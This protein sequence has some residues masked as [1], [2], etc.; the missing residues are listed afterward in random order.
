MKKEFDIVVLGAGA[1]G[2]M[3]ALSAHENGSSVGIFEK[4]SLI[5]GTAGISGGIIWAP[6]N[7]HMKKAGIDDDRS[8]SIEYFMSLS[9]GDINQPLLEAFI[10]NCGEALDFLEEKTDAKFSILD[11]YPDYYLDRPGALKGGGRAL[12]NHLFD[13]SILGDW[14]SKVRN[15]GMPLPL[16]LAETPLGGG[17]GVIPD[18]IMSERLEKDS[19]GFGQALVGALLKG[20]LDRGIEPYLDTKAKKLIKSD[21]RITGIE[22]EKNGQTETIIARRGVIIATGG[23][24]WNKD[25]VTTFLRGP[26]RAPAS[27]PG[28]DGD[29]LLMAQE[30]GASLGN[31]TSAW[32]S[33]VLS[34]PGD[35][36]PEGGQKSS[37]ILIERTLP[38]S[39][40]VNKSGKRFC[41][42]ATNYSALAGAF[43]F[44]DPNKYGYPN[45][46][47]WIVFDSTYRDKYPFANIMPGSEN[48]SWMKTSPTLDGLANELD[49][50]SE[51]LVSTIQNFNSFVE[52][53]DDKEFFRGKSDYDSFYGDRSQSGV[54]STLGKL[55]KAPFF[56]VEINIGALGTNGGARTDEYGRVISASGNIIEGLYTV[57]NAMAGSTGSVYAGA[58][59]TLGPALTYGYLAGQHAAGN[60]YIK[61]KS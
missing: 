54:Y 43:H 41:N 32:W 9:Q 57:G 7:S 28:N 30:A 45:L 21:E 33:P 42:E 14:A 1:S 37:P 34:I 44:F 20:C 17:T 31:M 46:P 18:D 29:G 10:D 2:M 24:E 61:G 59:G 23:F 35:N 19:R 22:I 50:D 55:E 56:A 27:P 51:N 47:A 12:D 6:M 26:L 16:T 48:P 4:Q 25:F 40:M 15:N 13:F 53:G 36:W 58:G 38:H 49:I 60:N 5:G 11:G 52:E 3:A 8:K 39:L